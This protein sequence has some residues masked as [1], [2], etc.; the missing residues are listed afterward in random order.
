MGFMGFKGFKGF[1]GSKGFRVEG[2]GLRGK[3]TM[4][5]NP[6]RMLVHLP[7]YTLHVH[8]PLFN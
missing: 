4:G 8:N 3:I 1:N 5:V 2:S 7:K 6:I